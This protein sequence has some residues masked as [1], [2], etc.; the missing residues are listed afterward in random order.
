M[1]SPHFRRDKPRQ[2]SWL[3]AQSSA[4]LRILAPPSHR[5]CSQTSKG[6]GKR[7]QGGRNRVSAAA[8]SHA[9]YVL[10]RLSD[11]VHQ[12]SGSFDLLYRPVE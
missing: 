2:A 3:I 5:R 8:Q 10:I 7:R 12:I 11:T 6:P 1:T 9:M 4:G